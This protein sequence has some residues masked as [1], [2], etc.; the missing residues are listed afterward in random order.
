MKTAFIGLGIMGSRMAAR[1]LDAGQDVTVWNRSAGKT[2]D[3]VKKGAKAASSLSEAVDKADIVLTML[4][5]PGVVEKIAT[6]KEGFLNWM[7]KGA[8][9]INT[10]TV[11]PSFAEEMDAEA[12]SCG[13]RYLDAPVSG[14]KM[15]A[16]KGELIFLAGGEKEDVEKAMPLFEAMGKNTIHLGK[17]G[18]GSKMKLVINL[19]LAQSMLAFSEAVSLGVA[20]GLDEKQLLG[21]LPDLPVSPA[22]LKLKRPKLESGNYETE[23]SLKWIHKDLHLLSQTA[24][25]NGKSLPLAS[26]CK[27]LYGLAKERGMGEDDFS[28]IYEFVRGKTNA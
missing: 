3:L 25:E 10:S 7:Q 2:N 19:M 18:M 26:L 13:V 21:L 11:N 15:P 27:D 4:P 1:L 22:F 28:V 5:D 14:S 20:S 24:Y 17:A 23:F 16:E 8:L 6:G 12:A 9:W